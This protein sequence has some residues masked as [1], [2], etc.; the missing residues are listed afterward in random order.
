LQLF[1]S[2]VSCA[3]LLDLASSLKQQNIKEKKR[4]PTL[5]LIFFDGEEPVRDWSITDSL[6]GSRY[7]QFSAN[8]K[9]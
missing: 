7:I 3:I 1:D 5:Q 4:I 2:A 8:V 9:N 6:Y